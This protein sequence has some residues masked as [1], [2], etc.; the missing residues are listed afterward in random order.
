MWPSP[1]AFSSVRRMNTL[2]AERYG[3]SPTRAC[4]REGRSEDTVIATPLTFV[5]PYHRP[6]Y[7]WSRLL[8][9]CDAGDSGVESIDETVVASI[10][11]SFASIASMPIVMTMRSLLAGW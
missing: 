11:A 3:F 8:A 2:F 6:P 10:G 9:F 5:L 1:A 4:A 7:D